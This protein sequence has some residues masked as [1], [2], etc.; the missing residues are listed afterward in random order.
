[1]QL[2]IGPLGEFMPLLPAVMPDMQRVA[3]PGQK[4]QFMMIYHRFG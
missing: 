2:A 3:K 1:M 4:P